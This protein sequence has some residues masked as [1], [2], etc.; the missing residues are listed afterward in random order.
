MRARPSNLP[1]MT[2]S[3]RGHRYPA[4]SSRPLSVPGGDRDTGI[5]LGHSISEDS[6]G[7][8]SLAPGTDTP[9]TRPV[10]Q[11][12]RDEIVSDPEG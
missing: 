12:L 2:P 11:W 7:P 1:L 3:L 6:P 5:S 10:T 9:L 4:L 8:V